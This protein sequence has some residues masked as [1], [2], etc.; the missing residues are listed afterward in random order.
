MLGTLVYLT[1]IL[2]YDN[3]HKEVNWGTLILQ[4]SE[5]RKT[6]ERNV[7][8]TLIVI[9][10]LATLFGLSYLLSKAEVAKAN[11]EADKVKREKKKRRDTE[12][13]RGRRIVN[14]LEAH[15]LGGKFQIEGNWLEEY[16][17]VIDIYRI[18][19]NSRV[20][21]PMQ[22]TIDSRLGVKAVEVVIGCSHPTVYSLDDNSLVFVIKEAKQ[23]MDTMSL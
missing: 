6:K 4:S 13:N 1:F 10:L 22:I 18:G 15:N 12:E 3:I 2:N 8:S 16:G 17:Y 9:A 7:D 14:A 5:R 11:K 20:V 23:Y 19:E 21:P